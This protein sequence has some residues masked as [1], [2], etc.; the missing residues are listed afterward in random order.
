M[1]QA[2]TLC[3]F[4]W[5]AM[6]GKQDLVLMSPTLFLLEWL[7]KRKIILNGVAF[8]SSMCGY[9]KGFLGHRCD[10]ST[11]LQW[12][13]PHT[14]THAFKLPVQYHIRSILP[15]TLLDATT[16]MPSFIEIKNDDNE[17]FPQLFSTSTRSC[18]CPFPKP[19]NTGQAQRFEMT[20][21]SDCSRCA[22]GRYHCMSGA[23]LRQAG[24]DTSSLWE[25]W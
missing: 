7:P 13:H 18:H 11:R 20:A 8:R 5:T 4:G 22:L 25:W 12:T 14:A 17:S 23:I 10:A 9:R 19:D 2:V 1:P 3:S 21:F 6:W 16:T 15:D 24:R